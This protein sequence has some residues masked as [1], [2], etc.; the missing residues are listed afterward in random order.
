MNPLTK[1]DLD[2]AIAELKIYIV[3]R[4]SLW[5]KWVVGFQ[6]SYFAIVIA[7]MFFITEH[8]K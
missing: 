4:E 7:A 6:L 1:A 5:L 3:E 8:I 2:H